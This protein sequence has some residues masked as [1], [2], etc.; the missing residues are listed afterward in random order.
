MF[1]ISPQLEG[2][3]RNS[4]EENFKT[5]EPP[6]SY[7]NVPGLLNFF[8]DADSRDPIRAAL[9]KRWLTRSI[10]EP[11][12]EYQN[13]PHKLKL[14]FELYFSYSGGILKRRCI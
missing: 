4:L 2:T 7:F 12:Y 14:R 10:M 1:C 9:E 13:N 5:R 11:P 6:L 8:A 3:G